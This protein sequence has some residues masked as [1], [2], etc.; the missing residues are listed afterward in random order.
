VT[1]I[2]ERSPETPSPPEPSYIDTFLQ[3]AR[4]ALFALEGRLREDGELPDDVDTALDEFHDLYQT[5]RSGIEAREAD[6][7]T[8][9]R[10]LGKN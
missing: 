7:D 4:F 1:P 2:R 6:T 10:F 5:T 8:L 3:G 9:A